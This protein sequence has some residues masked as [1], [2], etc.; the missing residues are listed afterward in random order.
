MTL[1]F[2]SS[3]DLASITSFSV[4]EN[5]LI[6]V[7]TDGVWDNLPDSTI[8]EEIKKLQVSAIAWDDNFSETLDPLS[9]DSTRSIMFTHL[10]NTS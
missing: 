6:V 8:I 5:D 9:M 10:V 1:T 3:P 7:A 4:E 2:R